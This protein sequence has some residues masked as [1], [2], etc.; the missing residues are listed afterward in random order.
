MYSVA[1]IQLLRWE[2]TPANSR[3][4]RLHNANSVPNHL[5]RNP[6]SGAH[7]ANCG[8]RGRYKWIGTEVEIKHESIGAFD[9]YLLLF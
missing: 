7:T 1:Y 4:I 3:C 2:R 6:Q 8:R 5:G 9:K